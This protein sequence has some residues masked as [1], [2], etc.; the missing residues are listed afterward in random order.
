VPEALPASSHTGALEAARRGFTGEEWEA[1]LRAGMAILDE[2]RMLSLARREGLEEGRHKGLRDGVETVLDVLGI[3]LSD[4]RRNGISGL[5][6]AGLLA[7]LERTKK[8]RS[9]PRN[10]NTA[11]ISRFERITRAAYQ[12]VCAK[13]AEEH[14]A[15]AQ[16]TE[17]AFRRDT[18]RATT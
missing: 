8:E 13:H 4:E 10:D 15:M 9:W 7:L 1:Y 17:E 16:V 2:R 11:M 3:E 18:V 6:A 5:D 12:R 14:E